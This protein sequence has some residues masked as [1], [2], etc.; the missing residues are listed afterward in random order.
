MTHKDLAKR[1]ESIEKHLAGH[2]SQLGKQ[3]NEIRSVF[4]AIRE[5]MEPLVKPKPKIGFHKEA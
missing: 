2:D 3:T 1:L 4:E 5:L